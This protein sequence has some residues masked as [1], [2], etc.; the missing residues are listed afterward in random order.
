[1]FLVTRSANCVFYLLSS[2]F[3]TEFLLKYNQ[4]INENWG[5]LQE[6]SENFVNKREKFGELMSIDRFLVSELFDFDLFLHT[7]NQLTSFIDIVEFG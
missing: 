1:M 5:Q 3:F 6:Q 2:V 4:V 7:L